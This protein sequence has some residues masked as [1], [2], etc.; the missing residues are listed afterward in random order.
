[1]RIITIL[2]CMCFS[3][4]LLSQD[5]KFGKI[6]KAE[7]QEKYNTLDSSASAT[8]LYKYRKTHFEYFQDKGFQLF[9]EVHQRIKIYTQEGFNHATHQ[10]MLYNRGGNKEK[11]SNLK[12]Y[13]YNMVNGKVEDT[14]LQ[15][16]GVFETEYD[17]YRDLYKFTMPNLKE[18]SVVEFRYTI[19]SDFISNIDDYVFQHD[20]PVKKLEAIFETPEYFNFKVNTKGFLSINPKKER[21][22]GKITFQNK[23]RYGSNGTTDFSSSDLNFMKNVTTYSLTNIPALRDEP[24]VNN[25]SNYQSA[26]NYELSYIQM[27]Q[28]STEYYST[29]WE[30]VVKAIYNNPSFG[31]ELDKT[32]YFKTDV[33]ALIKTTSDPMQ[34]ALL[35]FNFVK[36]KI[37]WNGYYGK[38]CNS[39]V[40]KAYKEQVGGVAEIN[41]MLTAMLRYAGLNANPVLV[42]TREN[43]VP[44]FPTREGYNYV[45][46]CI[47]TPKGIVLLDATNTFSAPNVLP[48]RVLNWE[49]RIIRKD[50]TFSTVNLY[51]SQKSKKIVSL[52]LSL[53]ETGTIKG[54]I[55]NIKTA[56]NALL[57]RENYINTDNNTFIENLENEYNGM[58][59]SDFT[60]K[61]DRDLSKPIMESFKFS[62]E[63]Q[64]DII[65][66][67]VY[68][69]PVFFLKTKEN[70][71]KLEKREFPV[72]FGYPSSSKYTIVVNL[73]EGYKVESVPESTVIALPDNLGSF[74]YNISPTD[75]KVQIVIESEINQPII[76]PVYYD[77]L[78]SYFKMLVEKE[79]EQIVLT[80]A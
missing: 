28:S 73:P 18:G 59:I 27:P 17:D 23:E 46:S 80:K 4:T 62:L 63:N 19:L 10:I 21:V 58:E 14:K 1:M 71:F 44:L 61:N 35:I 26:V 5:F 76:S 11:V 15:K 72:D 49:G 65:G 57:Y 32:S 34:K 54:G 50:N 42:S 45:I 79:S 77:A 2:F 37:K 9:T 29:T 53:D 64:A 41:L 78:K 47:E 33:E 13:T 43:G 16:N 56:N 24:Y 30:D 51:P 75:S 40:R 25:I 60:V 6:S 70:P 66:D 55:R 8:Y 39:G 68:F 69:S 7:L 36:S 67:K 3:L 22:P 31:S 12:A 74:K 38:Y 48:S 52:F 20:I